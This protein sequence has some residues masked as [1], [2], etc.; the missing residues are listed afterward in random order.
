MQ[1]DYCLRI[2]CCSLITSE[3]NDCPLFQTKLNECDDVYAITL[4]ED[5][6]NGSVVW[7]RAVE[8]LRVSKIWSKEIILHARDNHIFCYPKSEIGKTIFYDRDITQQAL[9][10]LIAQRR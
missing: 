3:Y 1:C 5:F 2:N 10:K 8:V 6:E 9:D 7:R 4:R